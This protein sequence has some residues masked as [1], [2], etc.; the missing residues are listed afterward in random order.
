MSATKFL[1]MKQRRIMAGPKG[2]FYIM[3][4]GKKVYGPKAAFRKVGANG[5]VMK[6]AST[7]S[8]VPKDLRRK[9]PV[10]KAGGLPRK[11]RATPV[12][13]AGPRKPRSDKG[14]LRR[15]MTEAELYQMIFP[16]TPKKRAAPVRK[17]GPR[18][19]RSNKGIPRK[20]RV[21]KAPAL[22]VIMVSPG[23][24]ALT[25]R[26]IAGRKAAA[27]RKARKTTM[28]K[29]N[30]YAALNNNLRKN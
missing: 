10:R 20:P 22:N 11:P 3:K 26:Q 12:R 23:G 9:A 24:T 13:K 8:N 6:L 27:T 28:L 30:P 1:N 25:K 14:K 29:K 19:P 15:N 5:T 18:K 17:A 2:G 16:P 7:N 4:D 21:A